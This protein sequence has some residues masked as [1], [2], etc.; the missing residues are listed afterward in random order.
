LKSSF[1]AKF[2]GLNAAQKQHVL[3]EAFNSQRAVGVASPR[4][5]GFGKGIGKGLCEL[6]AAVVL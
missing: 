5:A 1:I 6:P 2:W 4:R 3:T